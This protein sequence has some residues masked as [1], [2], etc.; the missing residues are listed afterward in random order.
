MNKYFLATT[1][2]ESCWDTT[3]S[4]LFLG[5]WCQLY[6][7]KSFIEKLDC[8]LMDSPFQGENDAHN[9]YVYID[10]FYEKILPSIVEALNATHQTNYSLRYWR[11]VVGPWLRNY[12]AVIYD[13]F[14]YI[15]NAL[16]EYPDLSTITLSE[17][18]FVVHLDTSSFQT[19]TGEDLYNLQIYSKIFLFLGKKFPSK[20]FKTKSSSCYGKPEKWS[21][22]RSLA[23]KYT[24]LCRFISLS[25]FPSSLVFFNNS[26]FSRKV[27][28]R[29]LMSSF[30]KYIFERGSDN[31]DLKSCQYDASM[32]EI[33]KNFSYKDDDFSKCLASMLFSDL[34]KCFVEDYQSIREIGK[35]RYPNVVKVIFSAN[36]W[37]F[38]EVFKCW[39]AELAENGTILL[40]TQHGGEYGIISDMEALDHEIKIVD[41]YYSWG[42]KRENC[43][44]E[45]IPMP[46]VKLMGR[47]KIG[48]KNSKVGILLA[49]TSYPRYLIK[50]FILPSAFNDYMQW[51]KRFSEALPKDLLSLLCVR[52]HYRDFG[53]NFVQRLKE[54]IPNLKLDSWNNTFLKS[55]EEHRLYVCDHLST[56]FAE[57]LVA[58]KPTILFWNPK[59]NQLLP[60]AKYYFDMLRK[61]GILF[62]SPEAAATAVGNIYDDVESWWNDSDRQKTISIFCDQY[63]RTS[64]DAIDLWINELNR[65]V[66]NSETE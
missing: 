66:D 23:S 62:D 45:V 48:A 3:K 4:I 10:D 56:T 16:E 49:T 17:N 58:N 60:E 15:T 19:A 26:Y 43:F 57:A 61:S 31:I 20:N 8:R 35:N 64:T 13:R 44:A 2:I 39:S 28:F 38:D 11:I 33:F 14:V 50:P 51:T 46:S 27:E 1:A 55:I 34:P 32:R 47:K 5:R 52:P 29:L 36:A 9:A 65:V 37:Y 21:F 12:I 18:S 6:N 30:G 25:F 7:R 53:W 40:G 42:W 24:S 41:Y 59:D 22:R 54:H 63:C